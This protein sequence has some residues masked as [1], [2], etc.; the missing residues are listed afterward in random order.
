MIGYFPTGDQVPY[1]LLM[2]IKSRNI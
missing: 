1:G 2:A